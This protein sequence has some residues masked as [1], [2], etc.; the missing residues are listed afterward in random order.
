MDS[1]VYFCCV[2]PA[3]NGVSGKCVDI[4]QPAS[5]HFLQQLLQVVGVGYLL[6]VGQGLDT[7]LREVGNILGCWQ[8]S[9]K[10]NLSYDGV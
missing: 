2:F 3:G 5:L 4:I 10:H 7:L 6:R 1:A 9:G 8:V